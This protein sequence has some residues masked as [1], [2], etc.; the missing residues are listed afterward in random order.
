MVESSGIGDKDSDF[1][2]VLDVL[3]IRFGI[4]IVAVLLARTLFLLK[5]VFGKF[6]VF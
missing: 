6:R 3:G 2:N 5:T 4:F 1:D